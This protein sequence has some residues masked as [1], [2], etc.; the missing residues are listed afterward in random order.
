MYM[1]Y[2]MYIQKTCT[3]TLYINSGNYMYVSTVII[4][5]SLNGKYYYMYIYEYIYT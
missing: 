4:K 3:C 2:Y 5:D 1:H